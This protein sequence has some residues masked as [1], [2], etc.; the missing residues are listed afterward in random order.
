MNYWLTSNFD[1]VDDLIDEFKWRNFKSKFLILILSTIKLDCNN[2]KLTNSKEIIGTAPKLNKVRCKY[3]GKCLEYCKN[4]ALNFYKEIPLISFNM[5]NCNLCGNCV[6]KCSTSA[7]M[8]Q[9][10][11]IGFL[12]IE[13]LHEN[14]KVVEA[15]KKYPKYKNSYFLNVLKGFIHKNGI[16]IIIDYDLKHKEVLDLT[17]ETEANFIVVSKRSK[18]ELNVIGFKKFKEIDFNFLNLLD[19][20]IDIN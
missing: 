16:Y 6:K 20:N 17:K 19:N 9:D 5:Q 1:A 18:S 2:K 8:L 13:N 15:I 12:R 3:C 14:L 7:I 11:A 10:K 4:N